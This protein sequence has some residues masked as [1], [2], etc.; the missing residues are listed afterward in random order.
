ML[1][2]EPPGTWEARIAGP[3][4]V[5]EL[6]DG[7]SGSDFVVWPASEGP[8]YRV[9]RYLYQRAQ[10]YVNGAGS[11]GPLPVI[12]EV[13]VADADT[14]L[15]PLIALASSSASSGDTR[16]LRIGTAPSVGISEVRFMVNEAATRTVDTGPESE[17]AGVTFYENASDAGGTVPPVD[18]FFEWR[19]G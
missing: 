9:P 5:L 1:P 14:A 10:G 4:R 16:P 6:L 19:S 7:G 3:L 12:A 2:V 13:F 15:S 8:H 17:T 11:T 18:L